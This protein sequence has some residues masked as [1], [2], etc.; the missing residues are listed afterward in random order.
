MERVPQ[1]VRQGKKDRRMGAPSELD[2]EAIEALRTEMRVE[3]IQELIPLGLAEV[4]RVLDEEV[5]RLAGPRHA[6]KGEGEVIYRH[7]S[8]PGSVRLGGQRHP[9][10]V[11]RVRG[12]EGEARLESY[13]RLHWAAGEVD[14]GLFRKVLLGISC[15]DYEAAVEAVPGAIGLS[16]STVSREFKKATARQLK[17][18]QERELT[19][20]DVVA[21]FLDG[22]TFA[23][24]EIVVALAV[25]MGGDKVFAG[26]VQTETE[27]A[28]VI[29]SFLRSLK[30]R[31]LDLSAGALVVIDGAK[32]L[33]SA[34]TTVFRGQ[35]LIQRC[36]WH[37]REN[38][39]SYLPR[40][41]QKACSAEGRSGSAICRE[42]GVS[43]PTVTQW[44]DRY[45]AGGVEELL[46]DRPRS[47]RPRKITP[48]DEAEIV[49]KTLEEKPA[50]ATHWSCRLMAKEVGVH[51]TT[52]SRIW[53]A[54][55]LQPHR[56]EYF[57]LSTDPH[58]VEKLRDVVGLYVDPPERAVVFAFDEKSQ[59][60]A[61]DRTQPGLPLKKGRAGTMTHDYKRH[62]TTTLFAALDV[63]TGEV[64]HECLPRH[65]QRVCGTA[66]SPC[67][68]QG[69]T[70]PR[71]TAGGRLRG[72][73]VAGVV[74]E[75]GRKNSAVVVE[76]RRDRGS[77]ARARVDDHDGRGR[78]GG[79]V[80]SG[81]GSLP[82]ARG[83]VRHGAVGRD[84]MGHLL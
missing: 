30:D 39:V 2:W 60:Q 65:R 27:N 4:G 33:K 68:A 48:D 43:R 72:G 83:R 66:P 20:L 14:E 84:D 35:V 41:E 57:K 6:R 51:P 10:R 25:T 16:K 59:I 24:D 11:P 28:R 3:L 82:G 7:G 19:E 9:V 40:T 1:L 73:D 69:P 12:L 63:A 23:N 34:V 79:L 18:F 26:F 5:E 29:T 37:K 76:P 75:L 13:E 78:A 55:G 67:G 42:V 31:G 46:E 81:E 52:I 64:V 44:L 15:R 80:R 58:F 38:V 45:E 74:A 56:I 47:G 17:A 32:G 61:L 22:K 50:D 36:Q 49:R 8:N 70:G 77:R 53:R 54:H 21:L 62:G 71:E